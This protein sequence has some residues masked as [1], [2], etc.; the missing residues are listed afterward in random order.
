MQAWASVILATIQK[1]EKQAYGSSDNMG[2]IVKHI[3]GA[4]EYKLCGKE[5]AVLL[6]TSYLY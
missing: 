5:D 4:C 3:Q 1:N 6:K 2:L